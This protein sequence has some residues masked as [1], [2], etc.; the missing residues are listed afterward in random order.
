[1]RINNPRVTKTIKYILDEF[2]PPII[3]D[4]RWFYFLIVKLWNSKMDLDFKVKAHMLSEDE[5]VQAYENLVPMRQTDNTPATIRFV[6]ENVVGNTVL[7]VGCGNGD[8]SFE[9]A[10]RGFRVMAT[11]LAEGN[12]R[13][14]RHRFASD[15]LTTMAANVEALPFRAGEFD[16][17]ICLH[18]LEH[19]R[20]LRK[21]IL[22]LKRVTAKRVIIIVPRQRYF[23][24]TPDYHLN[25]FGDPEQLVL[26]MGIPK[27]FCVVKDYCLCYYGELN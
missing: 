20:D 3:R 18:T 19:V 17:T 8:V 2:F 25:F 26:A 9:C 6:L 22:E 23:R 4:Q 1:M 10:S 12:L 7:E 13:Q 14:L 11:D 16:T 21:A 27:S 5:F 15:N 24:Y